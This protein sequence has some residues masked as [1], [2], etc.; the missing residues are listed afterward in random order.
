MNILIVED[1]ADDRRLL[2]YTLERHGCTVI[3]ARD[4]EEGL[5]LAIRHKPDIIVS[6]ALMP[7]MDGFQF[8]RVLKTDP[9]LRSIPFLFYSATYTDE[10]EERLA[11]SLGAEAF[12]IKPKEPEVFWE[13]TCAIMKAWEERQVTPAHP[14]P[15]ENEEEYL[16]EYDRVVATKLGKKVR[17]LEEALE[18][19]K[20][21]EDELR[22]LNADLIREIGKRWNTEEQITKLL[23]LKERL[24]ET[25]SLNEKLRITT[26]GVVD[27]FGADFARIWLIREGDLCENGC[28]HAQTVEGPDVCRDRLRCLHLLAGSGRYTHIDGNHRRVPFG[29]YKIGRIASGEDSRFLTND[30]ANDP[31]VH[32]HEWA[33]SL[34][35]V[36]FAGFRLLSPDGE[37]IGVLALFSRQPI[38][39]IEEGLMLNLAEFLSLVILS[40][41]DRETH[42]ESER[43]FLLFM[44]HFPGL[45]YIKDF[46]CRTVFANRGFLIQLGIDPAEIIGKTNHDILPAELADR[47]TADDRRVLD[48]EVSEEYEEYEEEVAGRTWLTRKFAIPVTDNQPLLGGITFDI[49][50]RKRAEEEKA[51][52]DAQ[53][54][55]LQKAESLGRMAG[56]I[57]HRF[58]NQLT[59]VMGNLEL[60][61]IRLPMDALPMK[62]L[63]RAMH[64][65]HEAAEVSG[66]ML[67]YLGQTT[68]EHEPLDLAEA[69]RRSLPM[70]RAA[71]SK[72]LGLES[73]LPSPGPIISA[74]ANQIQQ[75]LINLVTNASE[76]G[77]NEGGAIR[78]AVTTV[79]PADIPTANRFPIDW[80]PGDN[81]YACLEVADSGCGIAEE[82]IERLFDPFFSTKFT[83]RG[84]GLPVILGI[85]RQS[86]GAVT[87]ESE[88]GRG[89]SFRVF[90]P[91]S[92]EELPRKADK[93]AQAP[94]IEWGGAILLVED[95]EMVRIMAAEMLT[96][97]GYTTL[98]A[99]NC[100]EAVELL[101][102][103]RDEIRCVLCDLTLPRMDGWK[104]LAALREI[105]PGVPAILV[106]DNDEDQVIIGDHP[107]WPQVFLGKPYRIEGLRDAICRALEEKSGHNQDQTIT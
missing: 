25:I 28:I 31:Q 38:L 29:C 13:K 16:R 39:P 98:E 87:V 83:G 22:R 70:L 37:P 94:E 5:D 88:T 18:F 75:V 32:D 21:A 55:Q 82:D 26:D 51:K 91:S 43:R 72:E 17:E 57:A 47:V 7:R 49:T 103:H 61:M 77:G 24:I 101:Q 105:S 73:D 20:R 100:Q 89:S 59:S 41:K 23:S 10:K 62:N 46:E 11:L 76:A 3:E 85:V 102:R 45:A 65:A 81:T 64:S 12:V 30:V 15:V 96:L 93:K 35:L 34:G 14:E 106:S 58:N 92:E 90:L 48:S 40:D 50:D 66:L 104:T 74:N 56:A 27:I 2:R 99:E 42:R 107:E 68:G 79:T 80:R 54:R 67:T 69:C 78:L 1:N 53:N 86:G 71:L 52:I 6:D 33:K 44:R 8:L 84:L 97:L 4:G 95:E 36:S 60:A 63:R 19:R 9:D